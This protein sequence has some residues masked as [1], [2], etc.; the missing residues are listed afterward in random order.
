MFRAC[1]D[2][3]L[4]L[5]SLNATRSPDRMTSSFVETTSNFG[6]WNRDETTIVEFWG[7]IHAEQAIAT[8][9]NIKATVDLEVW[10]SLVASEW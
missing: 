2:S 4:L 10:R 9:S 7:P 8:R 5:S 1:A 6:G 3:S